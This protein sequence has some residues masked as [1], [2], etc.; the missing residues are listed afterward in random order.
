MYQ[1]ASRSNSAVAQDVQE[2]Y[3]RR[4]AGGSSGNGD[5][6][7]TTSVGLHFPASM[8]FETWERAG[9]QVSRIA[10]SSAWYMGDW[11]VYGQDKY[12]DRYRKAVD[13]A[14]LDYHTLRNYA[15]VARNFEFSRRR[16]GLSFQ[17]H[18]EVASLSMEEQDSWL[19]R[20]AQGGWSRNKLRN[21]VRES[22]SASGEASVKKS[23][24]PRISVANDSVE[25]WRRAA[26]ESNSEFEDWIIMALDRAAESTLRSDVGRANNV[27]GGTAANA[28]HP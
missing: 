14:G 8:T 21:S 9:V 23:I 6:I 4:L 19:D 1:A 13:L 26:A 11:I 12:E 18:A 22:R 24:M 3:G 2:R 16:E 10:S 15:W 27:S 17:H 20:A 5:K 25:R 7:L 28:V